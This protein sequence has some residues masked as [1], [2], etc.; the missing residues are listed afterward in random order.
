MAYNRKKYLEKVLKI[1][2]ITQEQYHKVGLSYKE[3]Y[4]QFI[5]SQFFISKRTFHEYLGIN[6]KKELKELQ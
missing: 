5:E 6:A 2:E 1:Q 4:Y 3:I